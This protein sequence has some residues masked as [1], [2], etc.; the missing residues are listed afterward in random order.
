MDCTHESPI[1]HY[2]MR[3]DVKAQAYTWIFKLLLLIGPTCILLG[4]TA[5]GTAGKRSD[6]VINNQFN[7]HF[8]PNPKRAFREGR[9]CFSEYVCFAFD[10][11]CLQ[12]RT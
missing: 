12:A 5:G 6:M 10:E 8:P 9:P 7:F 1:Q 2:T 4:I 3:P 11:A